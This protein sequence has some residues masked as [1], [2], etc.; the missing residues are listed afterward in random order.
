MDVDDMRSRFRSTLS[1][2]RH[3]ASQP[4]VWNER[5]L[6]YLDALA[7][8]LE[9]GDATF[10]DYRQGHDNILGFFMIAE[11]FVAI[12]QHLGIPIPWQF[13][14]HSCE[15]AKHAFNARVTQFL[16]QLK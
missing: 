9:R 4:V 3:W 13:P 10:P 2:L 6:H 11:A 14:A 5:Q 8:A 1:A 7:L 12:A 16:A 15:S